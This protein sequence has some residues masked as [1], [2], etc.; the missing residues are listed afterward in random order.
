MQALGARNQKLESENAI[1]LRQM[2]DIR[3][4][5]ENERESRERDR[6]SLD[7]LRAQLAQQNLET[8]SR[9]FG[10]W[11]ADASFMQVPPFLSPYQ[12]Y[13]Q[14]QGGLTGGIPSSQGLIQSGPAANPF[15]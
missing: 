9:N 2:A 6:A 11:T 13:Q 4:L 15:S 5:M 7:L 10:P 1:L 3:Q 12:Q 14:Q 8:A